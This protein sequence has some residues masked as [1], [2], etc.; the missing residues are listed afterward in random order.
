MEYRMLKSLLAAVIFGIATGVSAQN[1]GSDSKLLMTIACMSDLHSEYEMIQSTTSVDNVR[2]RETILTTLNKI[3]QDENIDLL[4]LGGD[5]TSQVTSTEANWERARE[6][7]VTATRSAF[8]DG[9]TPR[10]IYVSGN[11]EYDAAGYGSNQH[12]GWNSSDYYS[13]PMIDDVGVLD[14]DECYYE[15]VTNPNTNNEKMSLLAAY[16][17]KIGGIDFVMLNTA[18]Y[19][20]LS[21][22]N[23]YYSKESVQWCA[24]KLAEIYKDDP[25]KNKTVFFI[26]HIPFGDSNSISEPSKGQ[27]ASQEGTKLLKSTLSKYPNLIMLYGHDHGT[28]KAYI[29]DNTSQR[30]TRYNTKGEVISS[31]DRTHVDGTAINESA[32]APAS[33]S[34]FISSFMGSMRYYNNSIEGSWVPASY[35]RP[36]KIIQAL[37]IYVY[38]DRIEFHMKNYGETG[39]IQPAVNSYGTKDVTISAEPTP[40][41]VF[42]TVTLD[43][44]GV[45]QQTAHNSI[46]EEIRT[47]NNVLTIDEAKCHGI[48]SDQDYTFDE[49]QYKRTFKSDKWQAWYV[50]FDLTITSDINTNYSFAKIAGALADENG[51]NYIAFVK[52]KE[53]DKIQANTPYVVQ[54]KTPNASEQQTITAQNA[55]FHKPEAKSIDT[56]STEDKFTFTGIISDK[57]ATTSDMDW[58]A[59]N[60]SGVFQMP[61][62]GVTITPFRYFLKVTARD[63]NPYKDGGGSSAGVR[64]KILGEDDSPE[65][66]EMATGISR[67]GTSANTDVIYDVS[68]RVVAN[69]H[70]LLLDGQLP[71]GV[72][73]INGKKYCIR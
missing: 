63:D 15:E 42:R 69:G 41:T 5:Y 37:M 33:N 59:L 66:G 27:N 53:G 32:S 36:A 62:D 47:P 21:N 3:K 43:L 26:A 13:F 55:S 6:L 68:G 16:H 58:Y 25:N 70:Q 2:L 17:Y 40:Y 65:D 52:L 24:D 35:T 71:K 39:T 7:L 60:N 11:H 73:I 30:I 10:V 31:F 8:K 46:W 1:A 51:S 4:L 61:K 12:K 67:H 28:D 22:G 20:F 57:T 19:L 72:Y 49:I 50:P 23:Y 38:S 45:C 56:Q 48:M 14:S 9:K 64:M 54:A 18:E 44:N 29:K 34:S